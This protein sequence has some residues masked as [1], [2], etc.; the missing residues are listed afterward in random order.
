MKALLGWISDISSTVLNF[1]ALTQKQNSLP[2]PM[3][4]TECT[5][6]P[7]LSFSYFYFPI[8]LCCHKKVWD[9]CMILQSWKIQ[10]HFFIPEGILSNLQM[11]KKKVALSKISWYF[12][13]G[14]DTYTKGIKLTTKR[15]QDDSIPRN[16]CE[17]GGGCGSI[18]SRKGDLM[19]GKT[20]RQK[21]PTRG[22][23]RK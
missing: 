8:D 20:K 2:G 22:K 12:S 7:L 14:C 6:P 15:F 19:E 4:N 16:S 21:V 1:S 18:Y 13:S 10:W 17:S 3:L 9:T 23:E 11:L 5:H